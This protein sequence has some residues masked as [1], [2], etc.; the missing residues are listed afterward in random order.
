MTAPSPR[1]TTPST[2][3]RT[4]PTVFKNVLF[5]APFG[6][7][8]SNLSPFETVTVTPE[9]RTESVDAYPTATSFNLTISLAPLGGVG[10]LRVT[11]FASPGPSPSAPG[12]T[13]SR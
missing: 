1:S 7:R 13:E 6:P 5:P 9:T 12:P 4:P 8:T 11:F 10:S 2:G 3:S